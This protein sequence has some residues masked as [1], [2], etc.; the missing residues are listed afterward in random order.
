[1]V[2][3]VGLGALTAIFSGHFL[4]VAVSEIL[5]NLSVIALNFCKMVQSKNTH[6]RLEILKRLCGESVNFGSRFV[7][8]HCHLGRSFFGRNSV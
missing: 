6:C 8:V 1:M 7:F 5:K 3:D 4:G 2:K